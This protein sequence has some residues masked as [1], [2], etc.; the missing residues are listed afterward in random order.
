MIVSNT[1]PIINLATIDQLNILNKLYDNIFIPEAVYHEIVVVGAGQPG[2]SEIR[3]LEWI[4]TRKVSNTSLVKALQLELDNGEAEAIALALELRADLLLIDERMG[5][6]VASR[7]NV[8]YIGLLGLLVEAKSKGIVKMIQPLL[9]D[10]KT[11]AGFW[12]SEKLYFR[13]LEIA[14][15]V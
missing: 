4:I 7:F 9:N 15:E 2:S 1:S 11:K 14:N 3:K 10:L 8:K 6:S 13:I 12:I 5:R